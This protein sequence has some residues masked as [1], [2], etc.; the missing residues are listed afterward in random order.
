MSN[1]VRND[2]PALRNDAPPKLVGALE[3]F[4]QQCP[5][6]MRRVLMERHRNY[7]AVC[8]EHRCVIDTRSAAVQSQ[9]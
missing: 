2:L 1:I 4:E 5:P 3:R 6:S 8:R 7:N 9:Q